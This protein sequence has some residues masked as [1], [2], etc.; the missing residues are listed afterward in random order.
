VVGSC[1][2]GDEPSGCGAKELV[3]YLFCRFSLVVS[4]R[5]Y[6]LSASITGSNFHFNNEALNIKLCCK[7]LPIL[8]QK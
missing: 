4:T 1:K 2:Y 8:L 6:L 3:S 5:I 7:V